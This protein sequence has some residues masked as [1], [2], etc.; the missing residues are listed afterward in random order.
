[1]KTIENRARALEEAGSGDRFR[2]LDETEVRERC[3]G[4]TF[5]GGLLLKESA[6]IHPARLARLVRRHAISCGVRLFEG[7]RVTAIEGEGPHT[8]HTPLG[9]I[10]CEK[11]VLAT[12]HEL[13]T[14]P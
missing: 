4:S 2:L 13:T 12:N 7:S 14:A 1:L 11:V 9:S 10:E 5:R 3:A 8:V 6:T